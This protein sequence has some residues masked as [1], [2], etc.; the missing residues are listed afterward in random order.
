MTHQSRVW[1]GSDFSNLPIELAVP[2][3]PATAAPA[4]AGLLDID[5]AANGA[6][7]GPPRA[8]DVTE[9][10]GMP[11]PANYSLWCVFD[12]HNG[13]AA[14]SMTAEHVTEIVEELL[15]YGPPEPPD[16]PYY[17]EWC[18]EVQ[19]TLG[20]TI[21]ALNLLFAGRGILAGC[22]ATLVLQVQQLFLQIASVNLC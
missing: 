19:S 12:G 5:S 2:P 14:A 4:A 3:P 17:Q 20:E 8:E 16:S 9:A 6:G 21:A 11:P 22:T 7:A 13:V 10:L 18:E 1:P 15:P